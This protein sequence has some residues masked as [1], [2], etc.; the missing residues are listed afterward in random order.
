MNLFN[1]EVIRINQE[2][3]F[4]NLGSEIDNNN[5]FSEIGGEFHLN[6]SDHSAVQDLNTKD[7]RSFGEEFKYTLR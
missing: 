3:S 5:F 7:P 1:S 6:A 2:G 4:A